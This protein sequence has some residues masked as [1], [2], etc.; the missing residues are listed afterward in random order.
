MATNGGPD[1]F[2]FFRNGDF[3][4]GSNSNFTFGTYVGSGGPN[5]G[6]YIE[7]TGGGGGGSLSSDFMEVDVNS[8]YQMIMYAKTIQTGADGDL[9]GGHLG[10]SCY[11]SSFRRI[12]NRNCGGMGDITLSRDLNAGDSYFYL[13]DGFTESSQTANGWVTG[14]DITATNKIYRHVVL[15][16]A[17][18]PEYG[19]AHTYSR[20][21]FDGGYGG[22]DLYYK[23]L[24]QTEQGD[25]EGK[26]S[27]S[28]DADA[29]FPD[30][31]Y[32]TPAGTPV[33]RGVASG[34]Y[35]YALSN[36]SY[37]LTW[38]RYST[39][40]FTG[41]SRN[42]STPFRYGTKYIKFMMLKNYN[43]RTAN[44]QDHVYGLSQ[45]FFGKILHNKDYRN[46]L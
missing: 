26:F 40:F 30:I 22:Y 37:P 25:W 9:A 11:D 27:N 32:S 39:S 33:S 29:T 38:T 34:T 28:S 10:F 44:P 8:T 13:T 31:G 43:N 4:E 15:F 18:H 21:G 20:I 2:G 41:V 5:D 46:I 7:I 17:S 45:I 12:G 6:P 3:R 36:P 19:T 42:S 1:I 16:P 14:A 23:S 24:V 35:S